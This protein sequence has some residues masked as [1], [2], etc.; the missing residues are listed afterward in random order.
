MARPGVL[1]ARRLLTLAALAAGP[2]LVLA[3]FFVVPVSGMVS[4]GFFV[5]GRLDLSAV[6]DVLGRSRTREVVWFTVWTSA[7]GTLGSLLL[8]LPAAY[9]LHRTAVPGR[10][11]VRAALLVP[12]VLPTVVVG[13]AFR[14]LLGEGGPSHRRVPGPSSSIRSPIRPTP[15]SRMWM[16][17]RWSCTTAGTTKPT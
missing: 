5:D 16:P 11:V 1:G 4:Q 17:P 9:T 15:T 13:A 7:A 8:G 10:R 14:E 2:L 3:V 6:G 12:F